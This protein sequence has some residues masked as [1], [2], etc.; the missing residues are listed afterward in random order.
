M[1]SACGHARLGTLRCSTRAAAGNG[2]HLRS[3]FSGAA[4]GVAAWA[5][6]LLAVPQRHERQYVL[7][8]RPAANAPVWP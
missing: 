6:M 1:A 4:G 3:K 8:D 2:A 7:R 5:V